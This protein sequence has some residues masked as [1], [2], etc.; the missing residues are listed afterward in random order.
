MNPE[1]IPQLLRDIADTL[2]QMMGGGAPA[3]QAPV[4]INQMAAAGPQGQ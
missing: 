3:E 4:D 2:E 1:E